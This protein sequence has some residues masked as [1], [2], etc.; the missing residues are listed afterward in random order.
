MTRDWVVP[1]PPCEARRVALVTGAARRIG[2]RIVQRLSEAGYAVAMH[3][4]GRSAPETAAAAAALADAGHC[5]GVLAADLADAAQCAG[6]VP[7]VTAQAG[8][9]HLLVNSASVFA[10]DEA[11]AVDAAV[12]DRHFAVNLRAPAFLAAAFAAVPAPIG[13]DRS[14][15]N[16]LDQR[17]LR[18]TPQFFS[19]MLS[20]SALWTATRTSAQ[21]FAGQKIR[22]NGVGPGP[23]LPND[24]Q[25]DAGFAREIAGVPLGCA[26]SPDDIADAV[27]YFA[28]AR[29]V[30]GQMLAV[31]A[32]QHLG[33]KTPDIIV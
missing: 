16:I 5:V 30:T 12:W 20:K 7:R 23:V 14:I 6:L 25:G 32:G 31:D 19:Y 8:R 28:G 17:V 29:T 10:D 3:T 2:L 15:V 24:S 9:L 27:L 33:W 1:L 26:V 21:A 13:V 4:S 11:G 22:V 18:P